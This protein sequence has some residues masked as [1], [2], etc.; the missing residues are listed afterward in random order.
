MYRYTSSLDQKIPERPSSII[1]SYIPSLETSDIPDIASPSTSLPIVTPTGP[2]TLSQPH[3]S[4]TLVSSHAL[5]FS[6]DQI[7]VGAGGGHPQHNQGNPRAPNPP[8]VGVSQ[9]QPP[10][11]PLGVRMAAHQ[12]APHQGGVMQVP[13]PFKAAPPFNGGIFLAGNVLEG[14]GF[15]YGQV[16]QV[17][18]PIPTMMPWAARY[19]PLALPSQLNPMPVHYLKILPTFNAE[20]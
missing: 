5:Q 18:Q 12:P 14:Y 13:L 7:M 20:K 16:P 11:P 4:R 19:G 15:G 3:N 8:L 2:D 9:N 1:Q 10:P 17:P 6:R